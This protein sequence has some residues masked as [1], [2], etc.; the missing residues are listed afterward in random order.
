M[1]QVS[2]D[3][4]DEVDELCAFLEVLKPEDWNRETGF[5]QWTP[6]DVI[7]HLHYF[8][9]VS[10]VA[11]EGEEVFQQERR[12][13]F[14]AIGAGRTNREL[15]RERFGD[16]DAMGLREKWRDTAHSLAEAL[17]QSDPKRRLPWFGPDMGVQM[18]TTARYMETWA[19][20]Q[21]IYDLAGAKRNDTDRIENIATIGMKTFGWT[22]V[23]RKLEIPGPPPYV[24]LVAPSGAIWEWNDPSETECVRGDAVDFCHVVT[25]GRNIADTGLEVAG[26][27]ATQWMAI[28]QCFAGG[29]VDPPK[30]GTRG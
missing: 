28:A 9:L 4:R 7:G 6:W 1:L 11:L 15:A 23:N 29:P 16:L 25:Q 17:G 8:D 5:M 2:L 12:A 27:V 26:P 10:L 3:F 30:P 24:R 20:G 14:S 18:F 21:E 13:L 22:F 19:H